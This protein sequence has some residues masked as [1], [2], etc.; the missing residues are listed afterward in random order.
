M[1]ENFDQKN[2]NR[3]G[4]YKNTIVSTE[5]GVAMLA[6]KLKTNVVEDD[7]DKIFDN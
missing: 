2:E 4:R 1:V 3:G 7:I 6:S 5:Q